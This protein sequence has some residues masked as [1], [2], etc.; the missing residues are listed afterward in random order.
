MSKFHGAAKRV[1]YARFNAIGDTLT[2]IVVAIEETTVPDIIDGRV[3]GPK[4]DVKTGHP[5]TQIDIAVQNEGDAY[6]TVVHART[7]V[8]AAL[9]A[10]LDRIKAS[11]LHV[12]D[13]LTLTYVSDEE[14]GSDYPA[15]V[16]KADIKPGK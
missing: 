6:P 2:G 3:V 8:S 11:D 15:K 7:M 5:Q 13:H 1:N 10:E 9:A 12:G 16:Y 4:I 14:D